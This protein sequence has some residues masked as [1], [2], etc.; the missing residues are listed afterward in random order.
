MLNGTFP[1][2]QPLLRDQRPAYA[3]LS[4]VFGLAAF[5]LIFWGYPLEAMNFSDFHFY[6]RELPVLWGL[7]IVDPETHRIDYAFLF[8]N[9]GL[10]T[11]MYFLLNR[12]R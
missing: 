5:A 11:L 4:A 2:A 10:M 8:H 7:S 3:I 6:E 12:L 1:L 9:E